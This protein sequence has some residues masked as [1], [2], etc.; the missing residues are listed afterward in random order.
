[1]DKSMASSGDAVKRDFKRQQ[2]DNGYREFSEIFEDDVLQSPLIDAST[3]EA[4]C[5]FIL[6][7]EKREKI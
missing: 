6:L 4:S 7:F 1:M 2:S 3:E 5:L